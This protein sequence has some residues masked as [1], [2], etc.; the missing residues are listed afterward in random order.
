MDITLRLRSLADLFGRYGRAFGEAWRERKRLEPKP[1]RN[2]EAEFLPAALEL[3][4][5]PPSPAPRLAALFLVLFAV[6]AVFWAV[7]G[8]IDM[9]ATARGKIVPGNGSKTVQPVETA[10]VKAIHVTDGQE[11]RAGDVLVELD[12][13]VANADQARIGGDLESAQLQVARAKALLT[14][15]DGGLRPQ[16]I[17]VSDVSGERLAREQR[18]LV[19]QADEFRAKLTRLDADIMRREAELASTRQIVAKLEQTVP[20]ARRRAQDFKDLVDKK[21]IS[22]HGYLEKEQIRIE[23]EAELA[24][25][26]S[27]LDELAA[28]LAE[29]RGQRLSLIAETRRATLDSLA[30]GEQKAASLAQEHLKADSRGRQ[31]T[32]TAPVDGTIQQL[33]IHTVGGVVTEAQ[34]LM[35]VVPRE[36]AL[37]VEAFLENKDVGFVRAGQVSAVKIE[38]FPYTKYG[39]INATVAHVS[40][41]AIADEKKGLVYSVRLRLDR[42][43][44][45]V[46]DRLV[47][48]SPGMAASAEIKTGS[49]RVIEYFLSPLMQYQH[50]SLQ[51]R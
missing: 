4:E 36:D 24:M 10:V 29:G 42:T 6:L 1:R 16:I 51:E 50:E 44:I 43:N 23:Q 26:K 37:E 25:Q 45:Q 32:L 48:L 20:M 40:D 30:D 31:M 47:K 28:A 5:S 46:D 19:G 39:T 17:G 3:L 38:T 11:V 18:L 15:I 14:A 7:F 27:R 2:H 12:A 22:E 49:R 34:A 33:A 21:F 8:Q 41:D 35:I 13:T 9:V